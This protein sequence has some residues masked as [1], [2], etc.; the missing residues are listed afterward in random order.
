MNGIEKCV[1]CDATI[2]RLET[3]YL[4][5]D[6]VVCG[7][8]YTKL[9]KPVYVAPVARIPNPPA[10]PPKPETFWDAHPKLTRAIGVGLALTF[11]GIIVRD[12]AKSAKPE[13]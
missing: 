10:A 8:C 13:S 3:A 7:A 5:S 1:N 9:A 4:W 12:A 6:Q 2:G 11:L